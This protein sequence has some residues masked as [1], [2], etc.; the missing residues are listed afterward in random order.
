LLLGRGVGQ[1]VPNPRHR[2]ADRA[3]RHRP[4]AVQRLRW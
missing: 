4:Q 2:A 3:R 1:T